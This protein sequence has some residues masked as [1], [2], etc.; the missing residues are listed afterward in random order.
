MRAMPSPTDRTWPTSATSASVPKLAICSLRMAEIS[1]ARISILLDPSHGK[2]QA[3]ELGA[4]R[5]V[6]HPRP[7]FDDQSADDRGIDP[8]IDRD[9]GPDGP[10][11][12]FID[13]GQLALGEGLRRGHLGRNLAATGGEQAEEALDDVGQLEQPA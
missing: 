5:A 2:L 11:K 9:L 12:L 3:R 13:G 6:D 7:D 1:A 4:Q 8:H 10:I